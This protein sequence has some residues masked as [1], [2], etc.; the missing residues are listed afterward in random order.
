MRIV[1][2]GGVAAGM[3]AA[4]QAKRRMP[5]AEVIALE[6]TRDVSYGA[7]GIPYNLADPRRDIEDLVVISAQRFRAER[8]IDLRTEQLVEHIDPDKRLLRVRDLRGGED[9]E[10]G[11]DEL[12]VATGA[13]AARPALPGLELEGVFTLRTLHDGARLKSF[14]AE[15]APARAVL[16]GA[17]Y[18]GLELIE[19][20]TR[21]GVQLTLLEKAPQVLRQPP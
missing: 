17:G 20:L 14:L 13:E 1:V 2:I 5:G 15:A 4:S 16:V 18:V 8:A 6:R 12:I 10:L 11:Y 9:Y 3:S 19:T 21:R 7:C